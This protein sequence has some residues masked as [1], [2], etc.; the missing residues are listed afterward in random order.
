MTPVFL[1]RSIFRHLKN[2]VCSI[3]Y[4]STCISIMIVSNN[5]NNDKNYSPKAKILK[6][7]LQV[8]DKKIK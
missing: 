5:N 8:K 4:Q 7:K 6:N 1:R 3:K 2:A